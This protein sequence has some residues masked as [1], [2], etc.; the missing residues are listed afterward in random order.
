VNGVK[1]DGVR[2]TEA[3]PETMSGYVATQLVW[4]GAN[5]VVDGPRIQFAGRTGAIPPGKYR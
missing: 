4:V 1:L 5:V 2:F 3:I